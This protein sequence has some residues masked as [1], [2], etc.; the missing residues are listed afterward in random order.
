MEALFVVA[1]DQGKDLEKDSWGKAVACV[2][3]AAALTAEGE[4]Y[5]TP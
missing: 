2:L 3:A 4:Y 5:P 1:L